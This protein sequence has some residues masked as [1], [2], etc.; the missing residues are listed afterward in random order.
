[1]E[2]KIFDNIPSHWKVNNL[3]RL[4]S[5][6]LTYGVNEA[7]VFDDKSMPRYIRIT[8]FN[9]NGFLKDET[10]KSLPRNKA[11]GYYLKKGDILFA[12]SGATVGKTFQYNGK[13][14]K[15]CFAGYLIR[16]NF[17]G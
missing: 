2:E 9:E 17:R 5:K 3:K 6:S 14:R 10:F 4:L 1:M 16:L 7:A 12:R 13:D 8:D 15:A 11:K